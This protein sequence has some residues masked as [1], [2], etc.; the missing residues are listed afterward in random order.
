MADLQQAREQVEA[1]EQPVAVPIYQPNG[2]PYEAPD[3]SQCTISVLGSESEKARRADEINARR[4]LRAQRRRLEPEDIRRNQL[5]KAAALVVDFH[6]WEENGQ[7]LEFSKDSVRKLLAF[8]HIL[9]QVQAGIDGHAD[10]F[11]TASPTSLSAP[12]T[13]DDSDGP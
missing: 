8:D 3:G 2:E 10:F 7:P 11:T 4:I 6:G 13:K 1:Q 5:E 9:D 12:D